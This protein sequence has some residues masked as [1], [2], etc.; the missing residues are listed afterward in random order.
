[1]SGSLD[2]GSAVTEEERGTSLA[3]VW[4]AV[5]VL[6]VAGYALGSDLYVLPALLPAISGD[7]RVADSATAQVITVYGVLA[8][9]GAPI[10]AVVFRSV[11]RKTLLAMS[12]AVLIAANLLTLATPNLGWLAGTRVLAAVAAALLAPIRTAAAGQV[13]PANLRAKAIGVATAGQSA[14]LVLAAPVALLAASAFGWRAAFAVS[15]VVSAVALVGT[16]LFVPR[17]PALGASRLREQLAVLRQSPVLLMLLSN[18]AALCAIFIPLT[19]LRLVVGRATLFDAIGVSAV[20]ALY[21]VAGTGGNAAAGWLAGR[22]GAIRVMVGGLVVAAVAVSALS[23]LTAAPASAGS[24]AAVVVLVV[25]WGLGAWSY[26]ALQFHRLMQLAPSAPTLALSWASPASYVGLSL[27]A[28][29]GGLLLQYASITAIGW[30]GGVFFL[31][32]ALFVFAAT[33]RQPALAPGS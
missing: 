3:R 19:F 18:A 28:S 22:F 31:L 9:L 25:A 29:L 10:L 6:A 17:L 11:E 14:A 26:Y 2:T 20:F 30:A 8:A 7:L 27:G 24:T 32:A 23:P 21:G 12:L 15:A 4:T 33:A 5:L 1:M 16:L 13:A